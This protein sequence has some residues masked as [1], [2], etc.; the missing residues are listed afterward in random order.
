MRELSANWQFAQV[1]TN[2]TWLPVSRIPTTAQVELINAKKVADPYLGLGDQ[3]IQ[4]VGDEDWKFRTTFNVDGTELSQPHVD[5]VFEGLDTFATV[6]LNGKEILSANNQFLSYRVD[7]KS[8]LKATGNE[9]E[10]LFESA[11]RKGRELEQKHGVFKTVLGDT[12]RVQIRK[13]QY[14]YGWDWG[15]TMMTAGPWKPIYLDAYTARLSDVRVKVDVS[16]DLKATIGITAVATDGAKKAAVTVKDPSGATIHSSEVTLDGKNTASLSFIPDASKV[17][18]W[19]PAGY[20]KQPI[21]SSEIRLLDAIGKVLDTRTDK[22]GIRRVEIIQEELVGQEGRSFTFEINNVRIF[23]GGS[24][25]IPTDTLLTTVTA[26]RYRDLLQLAA[27]GNQNMIRIWGG[28]IYEPDVLFDTCDELGIMVWMDFLFA[29]GQYPAYD[30]YLA[31]VKADVE[32]NIARIRHHPSLVFFAGNNED[33]TAAEWLLNLEIDYSDETGDFRNTTFPAR[34]IYERLLPD[35]VSRLSDIPYHRGSPYSGFGKNST[36]SYYGDLHQWYVWHLQA[37]YQ[38]WDKNFG[39]FVS[40]FGMQAYPNIR[41]IDYWL[42]GN[43]AERHVNSSIMTDHNKQGGYAEQL[44]SLYLNNN[45]KYSTKFEDYVYYTQLLQSESMRLAYSLWRR[46]FQGKG[47]EYVSGALVWQLNDAWPATSWSIIDYFH[48]PK[49]AYYTIA[50]EL[51]PVTVGIKRITAEGASQLEI[52]G[53]NFKQAQLKA[54]LEVKLF[55]LADPAFADGFEQ[56]IVLG[57]V[58][59]TE[60]YAKSLAAVAKTSIVVSARI[61]SADGKVLARTANWYDPYKDITFPAP[62]TLGLKVEIGTDGETVTL[63]TRVPVKAIVLDTVDKSGAD[64]KWSDQA[65]DLIPGDNQVIRGVGLAGRKLEVR[66]LG[67]G[68]A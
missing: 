1:A 8:N 20:G 41:T 9:L 32:Q 53:S 31:L 29:D 50:R 64:V 33:Y 67:D 45:F 57:P 42:D 27:A 14:N 44:L 24:N 30:E 54:K 21:Y 18:L 49:L 5:L 36:D 58:A 12:S 60:V 15:P 43:T 3:D 11:I 39:R 61:L 4:W 47:K 62:S 16:A 6:N 7:A 38:D 52:W 66:Y 65:I 17:Q 40:E 59:S 34:Y 63:S 28:G 25:W 19:W 26:E 35:A 23:A 46:A 37:P 51:A 55:D 56:D 68:T 22:F 48:R 13:A 10:I 2:L